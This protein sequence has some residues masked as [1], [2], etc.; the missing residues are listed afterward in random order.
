MNEQKN[1]EVIQ[2]AYGEFGKGNI[3][4]L[5]ALMS[6]DVDWHTFGPQELPMTGLRKGKPE[7]G[8]FFKQVGEAWNFERFEPQ[9][10]IAQDDTVVALGIYT[11][12]AKPTGRKF[13]SEFSHVFNVR[14]G[15]IVKFREYT[16]TANLI[17]AYAPSMS[18]A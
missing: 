12:T 1:I 16:D 9:R 18:R 6:D 13:S 4:A 5:L 11:G 15:K 10:F 8:R 3:D 17:G 2:T 7:V 14:N